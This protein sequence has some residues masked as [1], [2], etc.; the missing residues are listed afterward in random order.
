VWAALGVWDSLERA[1]ALDA[2]G[3]MIALGRELAG[4]ASHPAI[5]ATTW[6]RADLTDP[7]PRGSGDLVL[8]S[9]VLS[10]LSLGVIES[11]VDRAWA[12]TSGT[13]VVVEPGTPAGY[14][15]VIRARTRLIAAGGF[16]TAPCPHDAPCPIAGGDWCHFAIRLPRSRTHRALKQAELGYEDEKFSYVA[17][18][19][20]PTA[21]ASSR[22]LRH[23]QIRPGRI[24]L[25]LC[26]GDGLRSATVRK[27]DREAFRRA[28][29]VAWGESFEGRGSGAPEGEVDQEGGRGDPHERVDLAQLAVDGLQEDVQDDAGADAVGDAPG[30]RHDRQG[31]EGR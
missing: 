5:R 18:S 6:I 31:Q 20:V 15:R 16:T 7:S 4:A 23:P 13:I 11:V 17:V 22:V 14:G 27:S 12:A 9:Y 1:T 19:R 25:E 8:V 24:D 26:T 21:R 28:R 10:E 3:E 30:Q 2:E 29:K